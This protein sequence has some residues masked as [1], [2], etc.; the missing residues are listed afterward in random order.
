MYNTEL[1]NSLKNI[2]TPFYYYNIDVLK[3]TLESAINASSKYG[4]HIHYAIKANANPRIL[5]I[6]QG[7]GFGADCVSGNEVSKAVEHGF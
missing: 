6:I 7:Y 3:S 1:I 2:T 4:Y 5:N